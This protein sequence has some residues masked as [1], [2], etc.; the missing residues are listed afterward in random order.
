MPL[1]WDAVI[2]RYEDG[3]DIEPI[4]GASTLSVT[5]A[6]A[7]KIYVKHRLW[8]DA[9]GRQNLEKAVRLLEEGRM[10]KQSGDF[11]DE[12]RTFVADERPTTAATVLK[13]LGY[14]E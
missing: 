3:A 5:G 14:L 12:Y 2:R 7:E 9:L 8:R 10:T 4:P 1:D 11:I 6:D 13:D